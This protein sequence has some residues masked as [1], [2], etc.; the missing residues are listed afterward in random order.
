MAKGAK[1]P[2]LLKPMMLTIAAAAAW[3]AVHEPLTFTVASAG[4]WALQV[5]A[6]ALLV[7]AALALLTPGMTLGIALLGAALRQTANGKEVQP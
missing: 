4:V 5:L 7:R 6:V 1:K 3:G 2:K